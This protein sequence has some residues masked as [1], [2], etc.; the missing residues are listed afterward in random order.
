MLNL[1]NRIVQPSEIVIKK[2]SIVRLKFLTEKKVLVITGDDSLEKNGHVDKIKTYFSSSKIDFLILKKGIGEPNQ[3]NLEELILQAKKFKPNWII[4]IGG[5]SVLDISKLVWVL[6]EN[7]SIGVM[8]LLNTLKVPENIKKTKLCLIP[9]TCGSGSEASN[10]AVIN[11][12]N[13]KIPIVSNGFVP[14]LVILDPNLLT[15]IPNNILAHT[16]LDA[17]VHAIES[18][19]SRLSNSLTETYSLM[20]LKLIFKNLEKSLL[21]QDNISTKENLLYGSMISGL[22]QSATSTGGVHAISHTLGTRVKLPHGNLNGIFLIPILKFNSQETSK[23][24]KI[25][26]ELDFNSIDELNNWVT[27]IMN[28]GKLEKN[29]GNFAKEFI[30]DELVEKILNDV[31]ARTNPR[32]LTYETIKSILETTK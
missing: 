7:P 30:I 14:Q 25:L 5:G 19:C 3:K 31:C 2:G 4:G 21:E 11:F 23:I 9:T 8:E 29:W 16:G 17:F 20:G 32:K 10:S 18:F 26:K 15:N 22:A 12:N 1:L 27:R 28:L 6:Y 24:N 13:N